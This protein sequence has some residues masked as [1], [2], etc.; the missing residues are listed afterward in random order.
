[1]VTDRFY[2][3]NEALK[4]IGIDKRKLAIWENTYKLFTIGR[5]SNPATGNN[6][7]R[8]TSDDIKLVQWIKKQ[9]E[10]GL[11]SDA[12]RIL[13]EYHRTGKIQSV[14]WYN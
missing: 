8:F 9:F 5:E 14:K 1:M 13:L 4:M 3:T 6:D 12:V 7:C 10:S 2:R 11:S